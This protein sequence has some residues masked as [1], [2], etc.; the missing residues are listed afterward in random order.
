MT[1]NTADDV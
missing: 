1:T